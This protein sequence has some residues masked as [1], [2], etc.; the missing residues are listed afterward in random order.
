[1]LPGVHV[2]LIKGFYAD[3]FINAFILNA[4]AVA[5]TA[6]SSVELRRVLDDEK[7]NTYAFFNSLLRSK[8]LSELQKSSIVFIGSFIIALGTYI[9]LYFILGF[10]GGMLTSIKITDRDI[11]NRN[12][13]KSLI[14]K[15][16]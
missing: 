10:G 1:M 4:L 8:A 9:L 11:D 13:L 2:P 7:G 6:A 3:S 12:I 16:N 14:K 5:I 15:H